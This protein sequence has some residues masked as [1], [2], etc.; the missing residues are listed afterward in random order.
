V[1]VSAHAMRGRASASHLFF[2]DRR[3]R[4]PQV[5]GQAGDAIEPR[6]IATSPAASSETSRR[7]RGRG[8][9]RKVLTQ[10]Y[11]M[12]RFRDLFRSYLAEKGNPLI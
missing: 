11:Q 5:A 10:A 2:S 6:P 12:S 7:S 8:S 3:E 9:A 1:V 4:V